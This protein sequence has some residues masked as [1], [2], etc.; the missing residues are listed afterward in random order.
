MTRR[1]EASQTTCTGGPFCDGTRPMTRAERRAYDA[2]VRALGGPRSEA[3]R[4][5]IEAEHAKFKA[6]KRAH[7]CQ[8]H[9]PSSD[10]FFAWMF[11]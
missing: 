3:G 5:F 1:D 9:K 7:R 8:H 6:A 4:A 2:T 11:R 10:S